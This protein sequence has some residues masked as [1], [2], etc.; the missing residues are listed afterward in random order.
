MPASR[1]RHPSIDRSMDARIALGA[2]ALWCRCEAF[3]GAALYMP[4]RRSGS[5]EHPR[6]A[7]ATPRGCVNDILVAGGAIFAAFVFLEKPCD[8]V[9]ECVD[10]SHWIDFKRAATRF[11]H[12]L[13]VTYADGGET[14]L[15]RWLTQFQE[16]RVLWVSRL[17][18]CQRHRM[19]NHKHI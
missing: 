8:I 6:S 10:L 17:Y 13:L 5:G 9:A 19:P 11:T 7:N 2:A 14:S 15:I 4:N 18:R 1:S 16:E 3:G 12:W